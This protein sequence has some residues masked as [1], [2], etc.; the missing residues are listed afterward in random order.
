[1]GRMS[2]AGWG[3]NGPDENK[4]KDENGA[5]APNPNHRSDEWNAPPPQAGYPA[6]AGN[7]DS[8]SSPTAGPSY[9]QSPYGTNP[10]GHGRTGSTGSGGYGAPAP[11]QPAYGQSAYGQEPY[12]APNPYGQGRTAPGSPAP[13]SAPQSYGAPDPYGRTTAGQH[14]QTG[15]TSPGSD[16]P[17]SG[18]PSGPAGPGGQAPAAGG[19]GGSAPQSSSSYGTPGQPARPS[20]NEQPTQSMPQTGAPG[21][22]GSAAGSPGPSGAYGQSGYSGG[23]PSGSGYGGPAA[24]A[25]TGPG[26]PSPGGYGVPTP[27]QAGGA[28]AGYGA[29]A[30]VRS[31]APGGPGTPAQGWGAPGGMYQSALKPGIIPLRP[32]SLGEIY[33]GA[34]QAV[35]RNPKGTIGTT[36]IFVGAMALLYAIVVIPVLVWAASN[37]RAAVDDPYNSPAP[38]AATGLLL[39]FGYLFLGIAVLVLS[40]ML[41]AMLTTAVGQAVMGRASSPKQLFTAIRPVMWR[42]VALTLILGIAMTVVTM[43]P[44]LL[45][46]VLFAAGQAAGAIGMIFGVLAAI[47]IYFYLLGRVCLSPSILVLEQ[48]PI[49]TSISR[50]WNLTA[51]HVW[52]IIGILFLTMIVLG[53][54]SFAVV[55][56]TQLLTGAF[57]L[58]GSLTGDT[59]TSAVGL[60]L[61]SL[62]N[63]VVGVL[64]DC[65]LAPFLVAVITLLYLDVRMRDEGLDVVLAQQAQGAA[66]A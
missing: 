27:G 51:R 65:V 13:G 61:G 33:D 43:V 26:Q 19:F 6:P 17:G 4:P 44:V 48:A 39:A 55:V 21:P 16:R 3:P 45:G 18:Q 31:G 25:P 10:S 24:A 41:L 8:G 59:T 1:M 29:A 5:D 60:I 7:P 36:A 58:A 53:F 57:G 66:P 23:Q 20:F 30:P 56:V 35:R 14:G 47:A 2:H 11:G 52:R 42:L 12:A 32:L 40:S 15:S 34:F 9:G 22:Y 62:I 54:V 37:A 49:M 63:L 50:S 46:A 38:G 64:L 28:P